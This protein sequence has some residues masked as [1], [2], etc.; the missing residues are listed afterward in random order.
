MLDRD[1]RVQQDLYTGWC[2]G[3]TPVPVVKQKGR[4]LS[5]VLE[6]TILREWTSLGSNQGPTDYESGALT[7]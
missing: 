7:N 3:Y 2:C 1:H 6:N 4:I 5:V